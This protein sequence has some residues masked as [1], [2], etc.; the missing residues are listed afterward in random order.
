MTQAIQHVGQKKEDILSSEIQKLCR[1]QTP[2]PPGISRTSIS[3]TDNIRSKVIQTTCLNLKVHWN[4]AQKSLGTSTHLKSMKLY[5]IKPLKH[6]RTS[7][8][9]LKTRKTHEEHEEHTKNMKN[10]EF[11][12]SS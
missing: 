8:T 7:T 6:R 5:G 3:N 4:Q 1:N 9:N 10:K 12:I 2:K 11:L